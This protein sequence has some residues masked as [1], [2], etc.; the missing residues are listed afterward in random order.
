M[1]RDQKTAVV[2]EIA[3]QL[4]GAEAIFAVDYRGISVTQVAELRDKLRDADARFRVVKNSLSELAA[5]KAG[6]ES[7]KPMLVGPTA[8]T[9]VKGDAALAA[10]ALNDAARAFQLLDFKG[11]VLNGS[12][13]S[14]DDVRSI[15]RLPSRDV[16]NQQLVGMIA[17]PLSG[18]VRTLNALIAG[19]A[20]QLQ[21]IVDLDPPVLVSGEAPAPAAEPEAEAPAAEPEAPAAEPEA[22]AAEP[23]APAAE[24]APAAEPEAEAA[25]AAES[26]AQAAPAAESEAEAAPAAEPDAAPETDTEPQAASDAAPSDE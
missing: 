22:P 16:L 21:A 8:L 18:L 11:G 13:L 15:A 7:L 2:D 10:K 5:D 4:Q 23:E 14:A 24:A 9:F 12:V 25:P 6:M 1:N 17:A 19:V 26:E 20:I 3:E